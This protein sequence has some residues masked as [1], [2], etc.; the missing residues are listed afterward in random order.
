MTSSS[1]PVLPPRYIPDGSSGSGGFSDVY[2]CDDTHL[3]R[4]IALKT[5]K[6]LSELDRLKDEI[7]ALMKLRSNHV[8]QAFDIIENKG[9]SFAI[10]MEFIDGKDLFEIDF[11]AL[12]SVGLLTILWQVASGISDIHS[13]GLIHRDIKPNN[14]KLDGE[15]ILK[16]FDFGLARNIGKEARTVGFKGTLGFSAPEQFKNSEVTFTSA[17][18]VYAFGA[19]ALF[20]AT[21]DLPKEL[22]SKVPPLPLPRNAFNCELLKDYPKL[23][24]M[25][26]KCLS[27]NPD[28]RPKM[29]DVRDKISK[30]LLFDKHQALAVI[31]GNPHIL[32]S[33]ARTAKLGLGKVGS[34]EIYYN[35]L[36]FQLKNVLGEVY[37][38]N[39]HVTADKEI[40]GAC[41]VGIGASQRH[42][43]ERSFVTFDVSN[44]EVAL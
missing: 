29:E 3:K 37:M 41:V 33:K 5:I 15:G 24:D 20:L 13:A 18:D 1:I 9:V 17:I 43:S 16:I 11:S 44:P 28:T 10:V 38:N 27:P 32:N 23:I 31:N 21:Q 7:S 25:F 35:G 30:Y 14:M 40:P 34:F 39:I 2:F 36:N 22:K 6:D 26:E 12:D 19:T 42:Y 8:V 4:K